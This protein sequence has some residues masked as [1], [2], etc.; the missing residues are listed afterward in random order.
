M[1]V[2]STPTSHTA[3]SSHCPLTP[4]RLNPSLDPRSTPVTQSLLDPHSPSHLPLPYPPQHPHEWLRP[5]SPPRLPTCSTPMSGFALAQVLDLQSQSAVSAGGAAT[6]SLTFLSA[7][8]FGV[9][10]LRM[11]PLRVQVRVICSN[12]TASAHPC[13]DAAPRIHVVTT[14][15][16]P[17]MFCHKAPFIRTVP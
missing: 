17:P 11:V 12:A 3:L 2:H 16:H 7:T 13:C 9:S 15:P 8:D 4:P 5:H 6:H 14:Q 1:V 10:Q